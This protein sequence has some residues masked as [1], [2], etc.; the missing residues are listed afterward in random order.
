M[1]EVKNIS[2]SY[3]SHQV[4]RNFNAVFD[5]N[6]VHGIVGLNGAGKS[7]FFNTLF[8][9][10]KPDAG[11]IIYNGNLLHRKEI[12][13]L[14]ASNYFYPGITA[15]EYLA[16]FPQRNTEFNQTV[17]FN[18]FHLNPDELIENYSTG[19]KKKLA[20][21]AVLKNDLPVM[22]FDEP[23]NGLDLE[24]NKILELIISRL[25]EKQKTI[26]ISSHVL[27]PL[28]NICDEIHYLADGCIKQSFNENEFESINSKLFDELIK[29]A[30]DVVNKN[31]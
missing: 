6:K 2:V 10:V 13:Y 27:E 24:S 9:L 31:L 3:G 7:T 17:L 15:A 30:T 5:L 21:M 16:I 28:L 14:E 29:H 18:L 8:G 1:I 23:F 12:A 22:I 11:E 4:L 25:K 26:F 19:M 20:L